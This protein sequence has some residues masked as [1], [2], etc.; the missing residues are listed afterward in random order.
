MRVTIV[1]DEKIL[2]GNIAKKLEK[3]GFAVEVFHG[4]DHFVR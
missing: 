2:A 4:Y 1:D 3:H